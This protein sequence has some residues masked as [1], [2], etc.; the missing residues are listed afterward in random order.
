MID[1]AQKNTAALNAEPIESGLKT[2]TTGIAEIL[3]TTTTTIAHAGATPKATPTTEWE[4]DLLIA[5]PSPTIG[6][7][8][9]PTAPLDRVT[10]TDTNVTTTTAVHAIQG[11]IKAPLG[12]RPTATSSPGGRA[13]TAENPATPTYNAIAT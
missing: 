11:K 4:T 5:T 3:A 7:T 6:M 8:L 13:L 2:P 9:T 12:K 1:A 10:P